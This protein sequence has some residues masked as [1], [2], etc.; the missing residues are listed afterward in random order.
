MGEEPLIFPTEEDDLRAIVEDHL[1]Y[2]G[3]KLAGRILADW[4]A[5]LTKFVKVCTTNHA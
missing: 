4:G 3:S 2:T 1:K 5:S